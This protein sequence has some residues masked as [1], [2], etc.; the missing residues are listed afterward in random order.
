MDLNFPIYSN[1]SMHCF[2]D[3]INESSASRWLNCQRMVD[4]WCAKFEEDGEGVRGGDDAIAP[5]ENHTM[6]GVVVCLI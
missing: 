3:P 1:G 5:I 4:V 6:V 2:G